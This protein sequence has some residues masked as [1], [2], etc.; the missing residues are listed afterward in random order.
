VIDGGA[1]MAAPMEPF[2]T[3]SELRAA[4]AAYM[5]KSEILLAQLDVVRE[6]IQTTLFRLE[7]A[8]SKPESVILPPE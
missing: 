1:T 8:K 3:E 7:I 5:L 4:L 2:Y 6:E